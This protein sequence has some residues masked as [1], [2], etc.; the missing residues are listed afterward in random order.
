M[1]R[2]LE[3]H[4]LWTQEEK[5]YLIKYGPFQT[6]EEI[7]KHIG[8]SIRSVQHTFEILNIKK[9]AYKIGDKYEKLTII[10]IYNQYNKDGCYR[11]MAKCLCDCG[12]TINVRLTTINKKRIK[13][14]G[15][16]HKNHAIM[17]GK[18]GTRLYRIYC[19]M[20][21]RCFNKNTLS[22]KY[23]GKRGIGVCKEWLDDFT[24]FEKWAL[25]NGYQ[26][27]LTLDRID[28]NSNYTPDN[29]KWT[30]YKEQA[31]NKTTNYNIL[32][33]GE[34]KTAKQWSEDERCPNLNVGV[35]IYRINHNWS[36]EEAITTPPL[37]NKIMGGPNKANLSKVDYSHNRNERGCSHGLSKTR[38]HRIWSA[39]KARCYNTNHSRYYCYGAKGIC[40]CDEWKNSFQTFYEWAI[41]NGYKDNLSIERLDNNDNYCPDNCMWATTKEQA[42]NKTSTVIVSAFGEEKNLLEWENDGRTKVNKK[43]LARR[44]RLGWNTEKAI[45]Q[46]IK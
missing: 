35:I 16:Y 7:G 45:T 11:T 6:C 44:I 34:S 41:N 15:C 43:T 42:Y 21:T 26:K 30:T 27:T 23:Y 40:V 20:K 39:M 33:F 31:N 8:R 29:C 14:C 3:H 2:K 17:H 37:K 25:E 19:A 10:D 9:F 46:P 38:I 18:C 28:I 36:N 24:I 32:A 22:Y 13:S 12:K 5:D 1:T 4:R